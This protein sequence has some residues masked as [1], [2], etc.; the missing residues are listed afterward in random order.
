MRHMRSTSGGGWPV[1][2]SFLPN[3]KK[4]CIETMTSAVA[5]EH[6]CHCEQHRGDT[7]LVNLSVAISTRVADNHA[8]DEVSKQDLKCHIQEYV[9]QW[10]N[11]RYPQ[12]SF[13]RDGFNVK[14][15][16]QARDLSKEIADIVHMRR[17]WYFLVGEAIKHNISVK[18]MV[19]QSLWYYTAD[20][21]VGKNVQEH[22]SLHMV[23]AYHY[24]R[25]LLRARENDVPLPSATAIILGTRVRLRRAKARALKHVGRLPSDRI[26]G[27]LRIAKAR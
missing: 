23:A 6:E 15:V 10:L 20:C 27:V 18:E 2:Q 8:L 9:S 22:G 4:Y 5:T 26:Y 16:M 7:G 19:S 17:M 24:N 11:R 25:A 13:N 12:D 21:L 3:I 1:V 14:C